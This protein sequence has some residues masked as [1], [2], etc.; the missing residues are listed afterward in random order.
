MGQLVNMLHKHSEGNDITY[1]PYWR[2]ACNPRIVIMM[3]QSMCRNRGTY[4]PSIL[5]IL[6]PPY[7]T[8]GLV[9]LWLLN[10]LHVTNI[11]MPLSEFS[12]L[13]TYDIG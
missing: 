11:N 7:R 2:G 13:Y 12:F 10:V 1:V 6:Q 8:G 3:V 4:N 9:C 5:M